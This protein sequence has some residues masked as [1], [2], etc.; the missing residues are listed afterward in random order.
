[1]LYSRVVK[2]TLHNYKQIILSAAIIQSMMHNRVFM[3][4]ENW[5]C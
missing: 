3:Q 5:A 2:H 4:E 1:M